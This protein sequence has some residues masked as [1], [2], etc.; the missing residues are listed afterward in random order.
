[1]TTWAQVQSYCRNQ[2]GQN[3]L[4]VLRLCLLVV[5][6]Q[7]S[8]RAVAVDERLQFF[9]QKIR[10]VLVQHC[11]GCH[12]AEA[13]DL[14]GGL[15]LDLRAGWQ[16]GGESGR[17]V[18]V[19]GDPAASSLLLA[20][21]HERGV[22][23]M[24]PDQ[25][26]LSAAVLADFT[27]WIREGAVD[28]RDGAAPQRDRQ[29]EWEA[30]YQRRLDWWSLRRPQ[31]APVPQ[32]QGSTWP[33]GAVDQFV[34]AKL[35]AAGLQPAPPADRATLLRRLSFALTGL[36]PQVALQ[37]QFL[38]DISADAV[39]RMVDHLLSV[40]QFGERW[41]RHW[42]DVVHYS[43]THG[44]EWD[45]PVKNAWRY[46]D[47]LIRSFNQDV[48]YQRF[49]LEQIAGDLLEPRVD[50]ET[51]LN[52]SL[53][54]PLML[55]LGE[56][57][58]GDN[59]AAEGISQEAVS[60]MV[61]TLGKA[62]LATTLACAQC[63]DHK[64]DAVEQ[65]DYYSLAGM[66]MS[67]RFS[68]R[69]V[70]AV[71][72]NVAVLESLRQIRGQ[73]R[74][75][76]ANRWLQALADSDAGTFA[77][78]LKAMPADQQAGPGVP[79]TVSDFWKRARV[80]PVTVEQFRPEQQRRIE[81]NAANLKVLADFSRGDA[82]PGWR[83]D[84]F[85]MRHGLAADGEM[86]VA[87]EGERAIVQL[88]P[89]GRYSH[90]WS[91]RL[92]G[93]LQGPAMDPLQP[94]T[95]SLLGVAGK[96]ASQTFVVDRALNPERM[97]FPSR[98]QPV[99]STV[100]AGQFDSLEGT[101]DALPRRVYFELATKSLNN[102]FPPRVGYGGVNE[103][104]CA[105]ERSWFGVSR[106]VQHPPGH[107]PLD[108]LRRFEPL[109]NQ[110]SEESDWLRRLTLLV[111]AAVQRW[112]SGACTSEDALLLN[113]VLQAGLLPV[114]LA[115]DPETA[116]LVSLWR[117]TAAK[118]QSDRT[119]GSIAEWPEGQDERVAIR[120]VY[121]E[122]GDTVPRG[123]L[124]MFPE[125]ESLEPGDSGRLRWAQRIASEQNPL[126]ARVWVN[127]VWHYLFGAGLVRTTDD[128]GHLGEQPSHPELLDYLAVQFMQDGWSTK[129]LIRRLVLSAVWQQS[130][131]ANSRALDVDPENRLWHYRPLR[132]LEAEALRD[133]LLAVSGRLD[134]AMYGPTIEPWRAAEDASKRLFRGP[135]DGAGRRSLY[136]EMTLMEPPRFLALFNQPL[137][138]Q[139][140]GRR[141]VTTTADQALA[142]LNDPFVAELA[143]H[144]SRELV[145]DGGVSAEARAAA[146]LQRALSRPASAS[147]V[148]GLVQLVQQSA[149]LRGVEPSAVMS[150]EAVWAD[151]AHAVFN[152]KE[153]LYVP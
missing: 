86:V 12:S 77:A 5:S 7:Y 91:A 27:Q 113:D 76:L 130:S 18:I 134:G 63:H 102:Y 20:M 8:C 6:L 97:Q 115:G 3:P 133:S 95:F 142:L 118:L 110:L 119:V 105:D 123:L 43:D 54:A 138:K 136:L 98:P 94:I 19:P 148:P 53:T 78:G 103:A 96:F 68:S 9:E 10:P 83:W 24:P 100:T 121:T 61:D 40:P 125:D 85:G 117:E 25:P 22:S 60:S 35:E 127:R 116:R 23:S 16:Q 69:T 52:E 58:H 107:P 31:V 145:R 93:L 50:A 122:Q 17:P 1:M 2:S 99:W 26:R 140:T 129:R 66:L 139:T 150:S 49:V 101:V 144:W 70:D 143:G 55:R 59:S 32:V 149:R 62:F 153:F 39:E 51:G 114:D 38:S 146:M 147:E 111:Q 73:L 47:Y 28:P 71:D 141:D 4:R 79:A 126:L 108:E 33:Q 44:Y 36:P 67:T 64:L 131:V 120:G 11:Y 14:Q 87:E 88:L 112:Q 109:F 137:P 81:A 45:V 29:L 90:L 132:R 46:R 65:R 124:R 13:Q 72:S 74:A 151:A 135:L 92:A 57:R 104:E 106:I 80:N 42:M 48:P 37:Q 75:V 15:R 152:L 84:G 128:F 21:Q 30:E 82:V 89:A 56:R 41:A 34:L